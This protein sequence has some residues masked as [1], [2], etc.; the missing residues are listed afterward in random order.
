MGF[1]LGHAPSDAILSH[2]KKRKRPKARATLSG[3]VGSLFRMLFRIMVG[4]SYIF[5]LILNHVFHKDIAII[6]SDRFLYNP[7]WDGCFHYILGWLGG[8]DSAPPITHI[9]KDFK[10]SQ[11]VSIWCLWTKAYSGI[12]KGGCETWPRAKCAKFFFRT[13]PQNCSAPP[14]SPPPIS[15]SSK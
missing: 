14:F 9:R 13:P 4:K 5:C 15:G 10:S 12:W 6:S 8:A 7:S 11:K 1:V 3:W 2:W